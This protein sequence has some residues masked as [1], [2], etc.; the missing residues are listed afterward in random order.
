[1]ICYAVGFEGGF[2]LANTCMEV[3]AITAREAGVQIQ[4]FPSRED[5]YVFLCTQHVQREYKKNP[6]IQPVLPRFEDL[7][8]Y[9]VFHKPGFIPFANSWRVFAAVYSPYMAILTSTDAVVT[10][11]DYYPLDSVIQEVSN[12]MD[13]HYFVNYYYLKDIFPMGAYISGMIPYCSNIPVNTIVEAP[14]VEWRKKLCEL[15]PQLPF[16]G[17]LEVAP[18][19]IGEK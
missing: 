7:E 5:A 2:A 1:M 10:F 16:A 14:C 15:P 17:Y 3:G 18:Q 8:E 11:L 19:R 9:P 12:V 13:A 4:G 6:G